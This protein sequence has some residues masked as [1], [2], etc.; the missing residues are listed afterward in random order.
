MKEMNTMY[1]TMKVIN[2]KAVACT[3]MYNEKGIKNTV[4]K[5]FRTPDIER[6][7][8]EYLIS[9]KDY[10]EIITIDNEKLFVKHKGM[11]ATNY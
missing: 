9:I 1:T 4:K 6:Y 8:K 5:W 7:F 11:R 3:T 2:N 10:D